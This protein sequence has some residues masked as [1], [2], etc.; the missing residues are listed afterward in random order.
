MYYIKLETSNL[1]N[2]RATHLKTKVATVEGDGRGIK[3]DMGTRC[4][5]K[6]R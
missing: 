1:V 3:V 2:N 5:K 4:Y 6:E